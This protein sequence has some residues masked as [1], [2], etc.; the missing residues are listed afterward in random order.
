MQSL[1]SELVPRARAVI[2]DVIGPEDTAFDDAANRTRN[3]AG[4]RRRKRNI[5]ND[6]ERLFLLRLRE[7]AFD[8]RVPFRTAPAQPVETARAKD[9]TALATTPKHHLAC[10]LGDPVR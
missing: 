3:V 2:C 8:K 10:I 1:R 7:N 5:G 6:P 9:R 4:I